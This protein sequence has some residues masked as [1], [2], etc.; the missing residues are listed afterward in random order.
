MTSATLAA[1]HG[2]TPARRA[3]YAAGVVLAVVVG[4]AGLLVAGQ[5]GL[6][7]RS[8]AYHGDPAEQYRSSQAIGER[9]A[10]R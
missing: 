8:P 3:R 5:A 2:R 10:A 7:P 9:W 6:L 1:T 4:L